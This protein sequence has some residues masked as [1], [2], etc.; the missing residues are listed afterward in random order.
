MALEG[1]YY[2]CTHGPKGPRVVQGVIVWQVL[3][4]HFNVWS[5]QQIPYN[6]FG[7]SV[8]EMRVNWTTHDGEDQ[9][10]P[11]ILVG[12]IRVELLIL[13]EVSDNVQLSEVAGGVERGPSEFIQWQR[14]QW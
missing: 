3:L 12:V 8:V 11:S 4:I 6:I 5:G 13:T 2:G 1:I 7:S 14:L 10:M 9:A